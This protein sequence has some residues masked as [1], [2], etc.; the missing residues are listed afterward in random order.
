MYI[1]IENKHK[2][3]NKLYSK[4][5]AILLIALFSLQSFSIDISSKKSIKTSF[6]DA[7]WYFMEGDYT[8]A[9]NLY[10]ELVN[11]DKNNSNYNYKLGVTI[12][13]DV[14]NPNDELV[15][16]CLAVAVRNTSKN[17][18]SV[19]KETAAPIDAFVFYGDILR[20]RFKFDEAIKAY[21]NYLAQL[22]GEKGEFTDYVNREINNCYTAKILVK[23]DKTT[24]R[25]EIGPKIVNNKM[26][27][28]FPLVSVDMTVSVFAYGENNSTFGNINYEVNEGEYKTDDIY[29]SIKENGEWGDPVNIT[30]DLNIKH[31]AFPVS[32]SADGETLFLVQDDNDD[33]NIYVSHYVD[34]KWTAIKKL[35]K[36][37]NSKY[38][39]THASVT[40]DGKTLYFTSDRKGGKGGFDIYYSKLDENGKWGKAINLGDSINTKYDEDLPFIAADN[41][42]L[43]FCSQGH[44]NIG[45]FDIFK[46]EIVAGDLQKPENIGFVLNSPRNDLFYVASQGNKFTFTKAA[47]DEAVEIEEK[48]DVVAVTG[49]V[50]VKS[51]DSVLPVNFEVKFDTSIVR[52]MTV[53]GNRFNF[54][55]PKQNIT[56]VIVAEGYVDKEVVV[57]LSNYD[58]TT[59]ELTVEIDPV[60][61]VAEEDINA[62][63]NVEPV[64]ASVNAV[65]NEFVLFDFN[66]TVIK[67]G[68]KS[69]LDRVAETSTNKTIEVVAYTDEVGSENYNNNLSKQRAIAVKRYLVN[70]GLSSN[71][72]IIVPKGESTKYGVD[73][74]NRRAEINLTSSKN[75]TSELITKNN[76]ILFDFDKYNLTTEAKNNID[77]ILST[78]KPNSSISVMAYTDSKGSVEYNKHLSIQRANEVRKY[79]L[80]KGYKASEV[81]AKGKGILQSEIEDYLKRKAEIIIE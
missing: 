59:K 5:L 11:I 3:R 35:N 7:E 36:N 13:F 46:S 4:A 16:E 58:G 60:M 14:K 73:S 34:G 15:E 49:I 33:G 41:T 30:K 1:A 6:N 27:K 65:I 56:C 2:Y 8:N 55:V 50:K 79:I 57:D 47:S 17:Y 25:A 75:S 76:T 37:I 39:E 18:R 53:S 74:L 20:Y 31:Q 19:Y 80:S 42:R 28:S 52:D 61:M 72:I 54:N 68:Y 38:W 22:N 9:R 45:G 63:D 32:M 70:K 43:Y 48:S 77:N 78:A 62:S 10:T 29:F 23:N 67:E 12:L 66:S 21:E 40:P 51:E 64:T 26:S 71:S 44:E 24:K 69:Y 81:Y